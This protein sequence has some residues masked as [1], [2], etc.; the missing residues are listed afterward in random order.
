MPDHNGAPLKPGDAVFWGHGPDYR[1]PA[2]VLRVLGPDRYLIQFAPHD[3][4]TDSR[5]DML[6]SLEELL[7]ENTDRETVDREMRFL[8]DQD[9]QEPLEVN[10][11]HLEYAGV[12]DE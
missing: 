10:S 5:E 1:A 8:R 11:D 12:S 9:P 7:R 2:T 4:T 6:A 3:P